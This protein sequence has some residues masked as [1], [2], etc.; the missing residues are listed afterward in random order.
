VT[1]YADFIAEK[2]NFDRSFGIDVD[3]A[4]VHPLLKPH[5]RD[6][7]CWAA[8]GGRRAIFAAFGLGKSVMQLEVLRLVT[9]DSG[10]ALI[11]CPLGVRQEFTRD[12]AMLGLTIRFVRR[13]EEVDGPG[14]YLTNYESVR[15]GKLDPNLFDAVSLDEASVL[16]SFGSKTYQTFLPLFDGVRF[17]FVA[18]ATPSPNRYKELIHYAGFLGVMDT[19]QALTRFFQRDSTKANN[20]TLYPHKEREFWLWL[21][22]WAVFLQRP[23]DLGYSDDGYD[24][25]PIEVVYHEVPVDHSLAA[26]DRDGQGHLFRGGALGVTDAAREKRDTITARVAKTAEIV[27][28]SPEDHFILWHDLEDERRALKQAIPEAVE[29]FGT[30]D[31]D[32]RERRVIDFSKGRFRLLATKPE[33]SGSG[34][35]FQRHC[36]RAVFTGVGFQFNDFYQSIH[37]IQRFQ[38]PHPVR[39]DIIYAESE[40]EVVRTLQ[41]KW[42]QHEELTAKMSDVIR[43]HGLDQASI[44]SALTRAMG[45]DRIE[46]SGHGW[47]VANNDCVDET[48]RMDDDSVDLIVTSI[49]F[50]NHYEYTPNYNDFGHTDDNDHFW[51]QMDFLTPQ[52]LRVLRPGRIYACHV[53]DRV[54]FGNVTG[55]GI[56]TISPFHAEALMHG[57]RHGF[58]YMGMITVVTDVVR[59]NNQTYRL[60][61]SE[62]CKD[63]TKMGVGSPEYIL[64]FHKPQTDRSRGY[65]DVPVVKSKTDYTRARWQLDAH[66]FWRSS[67]NRHLAPEE[68]AALPADQ[69][70][71]LFTQQSLETVYD[72]ETHVRI[73][74]QLEGRGV[75]PATFMSLAPGSHHP[76]VWHDVNRMLTLNTE[77]SRRAQAM[78]V[79]PLQFDIVDRL[80]NRYSNR[81]D[82]VYDPFGGLFTVPVRALRLGRQGRAVELNTGYFLDGVQYLKAEEQRAELPSLFDLDESA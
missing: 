50:A 52:L 77:Q 75:L 73:G 27:A 68:L 79:C 5:Q 17:R 47:L 43:E 48:A 23:S 12:A 81:G 80:I 70:S 38:Q 65:A 72:Y 6:I 51:S 66:A 36:H 15:D 32:E 13:G 3:P 40:R 41:A 21:N 76:D 59:E 78:H 30:L 69:M 42:A 82:L 18:T 71:R 34:C 20:L 22:T 1:A 62:Q 53:K 4:L 49:P 19:G 24:L 61:W 16:R 64:L 31:L 37:R 33:L 9:G 60:G 44:N 63:G 46:A 25:P 45:V 8:A 57:R 11:V 7:V 14:L 35:N 74:E 56:P 28:A 54:L 26:T 67:G 55:A 2:V 29:V 10:K 39:V 58:D